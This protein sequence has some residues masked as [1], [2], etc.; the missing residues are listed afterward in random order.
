MT[1]KLP[2]AEI[3]H[4]DSGGFG[5]TLRRKLIPLLAFAW[6]LGASLTAGAVD[7][8]YFKTQQ[9]PLA[10]GNVLE[11]T[12]IIGPPHPPAGFD[13]E[14]QASQPP[15][16][17]Q[18]MGTSTLTTPAFNWVYGCSA[19]SAAMIA[20]Y[21]D[22]NG[23][24][25]MYTGPTNGGVMPL[26]NSSWPIWT[27]GTGT[28]YPNLPLAA[29][30]NGVDGRTSRG[31]I[32]DYWVGYDSP[33]SDPYI[34]G[35]WTQHTPGDA[36]GDYMKTS[37]SA[38]GNTDG[39]TAFYTYTTSSSPLT[40][41]AMSSSGIVKDGTLGRKA[42]YEARGY[43]VTD[44]FNQKTDNNISGGFSFSQYQAEINAGNPVMLNLAGHTVV[45][46]GYDTAT[47]TVYLH[48]TWDYN[49]H[50]MTWG[51]SYSGMALL[52]VSIVHLAA[53]AS[54]TLPGAPTIG[55]A[56]PGSTSGS[57]AFAAPSN[58]GGATIDSYRATCTGGKTGTGTSSPILVT[59]LTNGSAYTCT[60]A[61]HN[62]VGWGPESGASNSFTPIGA[63]VPGAPTI[64]AA[65]AGNA[66]ATIAFVAPG[67]NGGASI[68]NY[69]ATCTGGFTGTGLSSPLM[70]TGLTNGNNYTCTVA[71]HNSV[72]WGPES[73]LSNFF[74][75]SGSSQTVTVTALTLSSL[76]GAASSSQYF[77]FNIP[78]G[79]SNLV[80]S[81]TG[82]AGDADLYVRAGSQ[83]TNSVYDCAS[84]GWDTNESCTFTTPAGG[85]YHVLLYGYGTFSGVTLTASYNIASGPSVLGAPTIGTATP[86]NASASV[87]FTAPS[88]DGGL[89]IDSYRAS[90]TGGITGIGSSSPI[91]VTGLINGL[92][93]TC[94][95]A[96]H[97]S[98][99]WGPE[100]S[101]SN[102]FT[103]S[104]STQNV[105]ALNLSN[106]SGDADSSQYYSFSVPSGASNLVVTTTSGT[107]D[108]DLYV[109]AGSQPTLSVY[110]CRPYVGGNSETCTFAS[111]T[112]GTYWVLLYGYYKFS[113]VTLTATFVAASGATVP[114]APTIGVATAVRG[115]VRVAFTAPASNGGASIDSY[116]AT[117][118]GGKTAAAASSPITVY[119][120]SSESR[121]T[122]TVAAHNSVGWGPESAA[123]NGVTPLVGKAFDLAP[124]L[125]LLLD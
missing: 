105:T 69:R 56:V 101:P 27:D 104:G 53:P 58:N 54:T 114:G 110:D 72:G 26:N 49:T 45:G 96:A 66:S 100:S 74:T 62:S 1:D 78:L 55:T 108:A 24:P 77:S 7:T 121:Y 103:P 47:S 84:E 35:G 118:T 3:P 22:R 16:V 107:G 106:L 116:R 71:A 48:D 12:I 64:G 125:M 67:S 15:E 83:P 76:S 2:Y 120:L 97:N 28:T 68:D 46:V 17:N 75:P 115:G 60:V 31:S 14:R 38:H 59:N 99:G 124:I 10:D 119:G 111:P 18:A 30:K 113:G 11:E 88:S 32:D 91:V 61:A 89:S 13:V 37:Q 117:C 29:S 63:S 5:K 9:I 43:T 95:V 109:R 36:L 65:T 51:S 122:C 19:V 42:F 6:F 112:A 23:Y 86:G 4:S 40:C 25:N 39:S 82:G 21:Y 34:T 8:E 41:A 93:Y 57:V 50:S 98:E 102:Y 79:S 73:G 87:A 52:S 44:C 92:I 85:T 94:T 81:T 80:V 90:C 33:D 123:S 20:G 70:V